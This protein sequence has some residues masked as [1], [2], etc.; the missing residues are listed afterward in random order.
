M[1]SRSGVTQWVRGFLS[2]RG[3]EDRV[4]PK[5]SAVFFLA[6]YGPPQTVAGRGACRYPAPAPRPSNIRRQ[7][8]PR[9]DRV[10]CADAHTFYICR[11]RCASHRVV[12]GGG[13]RSAGDAS[14]QQA[15]VERGAL[16]AL[17]VSN[18]EPVLCSIHVERSRGAGGGIRRVTGPKKRAEVGCNRWW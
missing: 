2:R 8:Q 7:P 15:Y 12:T 14:A 11:T 17:P 9:V 18:V 13:G 4:S 6:K 1:S 3:R 10:A 16:H 5:G